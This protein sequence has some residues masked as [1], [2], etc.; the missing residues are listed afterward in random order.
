MI[1]TDDDSFAAACRAFRNQGREG[2]AWLA[3][4]RLGY[5]YRL[6]EINAALGVAQITRLEE[7]LA[8][9]RRVAHLYVDRLMTNRY[10]ILPTLAGR[11]AHELVRLRRSAQ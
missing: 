8:N 5:N 7:I 11:H 9:R 3:H 2:M 4:Q 6:S 10:L 1:V